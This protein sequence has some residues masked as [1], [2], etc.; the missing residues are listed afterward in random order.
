[1]SNVA[2]YDANYK[3]QQ[4]TK[5][6]PTSNDGCVSN[7]D[8]QKKLNTTDF[9]KQLGGVISQ[10]TGFLNSYMQDQNDIK[11]KTAEKKLA[12]D[13]DRLWQTAVNKKRQLLDRHNSIIK[14][15]N[16]EYNTTQQVH[17]SLHNTK[18]L[19]TMLEKQNNE[20]KKM[21]EGEIHT[22]ELSDRKTYYE[23]EQNTW[24][25]WWSNQF[26]SNYWLLIFLLVLAIGITNR[27]KDKQ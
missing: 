5:T 9:N 19:F 24:I 27:L 12:I 25:E 3:E 26:K 18:Q 7:D 16:N 20:L 15:L 8:L 13:N 14:M 22:I 11:N 2:K 10:A 21:V 6:K 23:N 17:S 4:K 1:M